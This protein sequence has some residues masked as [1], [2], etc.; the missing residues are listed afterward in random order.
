MAIQ[1]RTIPS[2][3]GLVTSLPADKIADRNASEC[4]GMDFSIDGLAQTNRGYDQF[5]NRILTAGS[6]PRIFTY[7]KNFGTLKDILF[8]VRDTGTEQILEW[9]NPSNISNNLDGYW[10]KLKGGLTTGK[11]LGHAPANGDGGAKTN[12][13]VFG[14]AADNMMVWNGSTGLVDSATTDTIV[15]KEDIAAEGFDVSGGKLMVN[16]TEYTYTGISGSTFTGVSPDASALVEN[17]GVAQSIDADILTEHILL[18]QT[19]IAFVHNQPADNDTITDSNNGFGTAGFTAGQKIAI[20]GSSKVLNNR[21]LTIKTVTDGTI[22]LS[23]TDVVDPIAAGD[24][25]TIAAGAPKGNVLLTTQRKLFLSGVDTNESKVHY[26]E[27]GEVTSFGI[28]SGLGSGGSFD[29]M[30]GGGPVTLM[31][32]RGKNTV[33]VHKADAIIAYTRNNDGTNAIEDFE[34][35][36]SG[37]GVGSSNILGETFIDKDSYFVSGIGGIKRIADI[38]AYD[39]SRALDLKTITDIISPTIEH[40]DFSTASICYFPQ[41]RVLLVACNNAD[42]DR[43]TIAIYSKKTPEGQYYYDISIDPIPA[44]EFAVVGNNLYFASSLDQNVY[45]MYTRLSANGEKLPHRWASK[46]FTFTEP[47]I[48]KSFSK[49]YIEG[50]MSSEAKIKVSVVYGML[51]EKGTKVETITVNTE[52]VSGTDIS[53]L[54]TEIIGETSIGASLQNINDSRYFNIPL[55]FDVNKANRYKII[56]ESAYDETTGESETYWAINNIATNPAGLTVDQGATVN[57]NL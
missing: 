9:L 25:I 42:G 22:T 45:K 40:Y 18:K 4:V 38:I 6:R 12:K 50:F 34:T 15:I 21:V 11:I 14:N 30:E 43:V 8:S 20:A 47:A 1:F 32:S 33:L 27:S 5:A 57:T 46:E 37:E 54:G 53:A 3:G 55:H 10:E 35:L 23:D 31:E 29:L 2:L 56:I 36:S 24:I 13:I 41:K 28:T 17:M 52:G 48:L 49:L 39:G 7:K 16:E 44:N 26:S 51:G 19:T